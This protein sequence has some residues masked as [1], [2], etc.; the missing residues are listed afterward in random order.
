[1]HKELDEEKDK[2][3]IEKK[4]KNK[5]E[6]L[7]DWQIGNWHVFVVKKTKDENGRSKVEIVMSIERM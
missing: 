5:S 2:T 1:M 7:V 3:K 6:K 4:I